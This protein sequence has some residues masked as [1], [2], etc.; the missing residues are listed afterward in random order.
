MGG[1]DCLKEGAWGLGQFA[2]L[3]WGLARKREKGGCFLVGVD[4]SMH[5][6]VSGNSPETLRKL[7]VSAKFPHQK[8]R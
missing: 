6:M 7:I 2:D 4:T 8:I 1:G 5:T 3:R